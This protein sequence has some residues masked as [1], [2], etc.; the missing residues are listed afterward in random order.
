MLAN[1]VRA[2]KVLYQLQDTDE[3]TSS[4][5]NCIKSKD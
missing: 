5:I 1:K 2:K 3:E 4:L